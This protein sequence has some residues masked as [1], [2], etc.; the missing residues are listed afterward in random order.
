[1]K[2][3][4][5]EDSFRLLFET[6]VTKLLISDRIAMLLSSRGNSDAVGEW[7]A[8]DGCD[9]AHNV[10]DMACKFKAYMDLRGTSP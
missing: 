2:A 5:R 4:G 3:G 9:V 1:M 8:D 7:L 10:R 6:S